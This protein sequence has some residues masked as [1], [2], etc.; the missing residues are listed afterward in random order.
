MSIS[1]GAVRMLE[2][3]LLL[4]P[5]LSTIQ[6]KDIS[7]GSSLWD[8][9]DTSLYDSFPSSDFTDVLKEVPRGK[10]EEKSVYDAVRMPG[11]RWCGKGWRTAS[12]YKLDGYS[13][14]DRCCRQHDLGCSIS[15]QPGETKYGLTNMRF[16]TVMHCSCDDRFRSCL[17]MTRSGAGDTVGNLFFNVSNTPCFVF[18]KKERC[19]ARNWWGTCLKKELKKTAVWRKTMPY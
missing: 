1:C 2:R 5:F 9:P 6:T 4:L 17:K 10:N 18:T 15:I 11:T 13:S 14:A 19:V 7:G 3:T 16:H 8:T 12:F